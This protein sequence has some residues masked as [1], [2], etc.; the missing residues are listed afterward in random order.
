M[1]PTNIGGSPPDPNQLPSL[2]TTEW[3][4][5]NTITKIVPSSPTRR[6]PVKITSNPFDYDDDD[7]YENE[8][9][10]DDD[11]DDDDEDND[12]SMG[13]KQAATPN[14][15]ITS[16]QKEQA[17]ANLNARAMKAHIITPEKSAGSNDDHLL[18]SV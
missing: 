9:D 14:K 10:D 17:N 2:T 18:D 7:Y 13:R 5:L 16:L 15:I 1:G 4:T 12:N 8:N 11:D 6:N 3:P